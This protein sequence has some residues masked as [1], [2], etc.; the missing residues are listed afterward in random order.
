MK[1]EHTPLS[2]TLAGGIDY[3]LD[4]LT[5][6]KSRLEASSVISFDFDEEIGECE[7]FFRVIDM[8]LSHQT[9][10][11]ADNYTIEEVRRNGNK[12]TITGR[13]EQIILEHLNRTNP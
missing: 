3:L 7:I 9:D 13:Q 8:A 4:K 5:K 1:Y 2:V 10:E 12:I 6:P 11:S